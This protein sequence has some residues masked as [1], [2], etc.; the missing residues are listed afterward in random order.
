[1]THTELAAQAL[2]QVG[3]ALPGAEVAVE[4]TEHEMALTRFAESVIHQ[5]VAEALTT[6]RVIVHDQGRTAST[7]GT[8][9]G[10]ADLPDIVE[11]IRTA[12]G[13][14]PNDGGWPGLAPAAAPGAAAPPDPGTVA[15][16]PVDRAELVA[17]FVDGA[18]GLESAGYVRTSHRWVAFANSAGQAVDG[19][20]AEC[21]LAGVARAPAAVGMA[22]GVARVMPVRLADVDA[23]AMGARAAAKA[24]AWREPVEL[25]PG[26]Y[27]VVLEP[28]A[29]SDILGNLAT[30]GFAGRMVTERRSFVELGAD[31]LD[32]ALTIVDDPVAVSLG[33]D[34]EGTPSAR[35]TFVEAGRPVAVAYDRR[36]AAEAGVESTGHSVVGWGGGGALARHLGILPVGPEDAR[37]GEVDGPMC[38]SST[39]ELVAGVER[40]ILVSDFWY[41]RVL[42]SRALVLTGLTRNGVWLVEDGQVTTPVKN[43]RFTQS[44]SEA[45]APGQVLG[46]GRTATPIPGD[47]YSSTSP[48]LGCPALRLA[49]W[50]FTGGASG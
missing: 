39:A 13:V 23:R 10:T 26:R 28:D 44:Y 7:S 11:R 40:G 34:A 9:A 3:A 15:A 35:R 8:V 31:Q 29:V 25:D 41:T 20:A 5:N 17:G 14:A 49:S 12:V 36:T 1:M 27:E 16:S 18:G 43:F 47:T 19:E 50:N 33:F 22:D 6:V 32:P 2:E 4:V 48:R 30:S 38:D 21:G 46:V 24:R 42:D 37:V 45:L